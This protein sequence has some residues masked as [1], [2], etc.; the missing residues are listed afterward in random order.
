MKI[1]KLLYIKYIASF[2]ICL[3]SSFIVFFIFSLISNLSED[4]LFRIILIL[5]GLN[6]LQILTYVPAFI[7]LISLI[8]FS[9]FLRSKN[10][11]IIIK[12]YL[13]IHKLMVFV[14][15][16]V[17]LFSVFESNKKRIS[18]YLD[19]SKSNLIE[20]KEST[21]TK[22]LIK[23]TNNKK[24]ITILENLDLTDMSNAKYRSFNIFNNVINIAQY[25]EKLI[26][27]ENTLT[28]ENY[29][30]YENDIIEDFN[31]Q[32]I[33]N[34]DLINLISDSSLV[35][36]LSVKSNPL[37][38]V[39]LIN[40]ITF[41]IFFLS[42]IFLIFFNSQ[43]IG[44]KQSLRNPI[45]ISLSMLIYSF[46]IFNNSLVTYKQEFELLASLIV[47]MLFFRAYLNE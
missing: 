41:F 10:E 33:I 46:I 4:Y 44:S 2:L 12:S 13:G 5:S 37:L 30:Q 25:S 6:S 19:D 8:L 22:I 47:L 1:I 45:L 7:F 9:V 24:T 17:L 28:L 15:P 21:K 20:S 34:I 29:T 43:Y 35:K 18:I 36:I 16:I 32:K 27:S 31:S 23:E 14:L 3:S 40:L 39:K 26:A 11:V 42:F 38:N